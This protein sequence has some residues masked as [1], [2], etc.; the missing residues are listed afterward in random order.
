MMMK[1]YGCMRAGYTIIE[2][3]VVIAIAT[4]LLSIL[5][6]AVQVA[7]ESS[8]R[9]S[10]QNNLRQFGV[11]LALLAER[12]GEF[13]VCSIKGR[14]FLDF[15]PI[16]EQAELE[17][18]IRANIFGMNPNVPVFC[19]SSDPVIWEKNSNGYGDSSYLLNRGTEFPST[20]ADGV[21][22]ALG[23]TNGFIVSAKVNTRPSDISDGLSNTVAMSERLAIPAKE[24]GR[25][26][27][28]NRIDALR[29]LWWTEKRFVGDGEEPLAADQARNHRTTVIPMA[30]GG[31]TSSYLAGHYD[32][33]LPPNVPGTHNGP[34]DNDYARSSRYSLISASSLHSGGVQSLFADG[35]V[36]FINESIDL[37][38]WQAM[39][40][41]NGG[42]VISP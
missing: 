26:D 28:L 7:R 20:D 3:M 31:L 25:P 40:T 23:P 17:A 8:R 13:P 36:Q 37:R 35:S 21:R 1:N 27:K 14:P 12:N 24:S 29:H 6:P 2:V 41:R 16:F 32:H 5:V 18:R 19:C 42:E 15:L 22:D 34:E 10:C 9:A 30:I 11:A 38:V 33:I 39:G 4:V